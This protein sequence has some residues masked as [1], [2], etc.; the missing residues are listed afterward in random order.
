MTEPARLL[1][2][3]D[4][5]LGGDYA[6]R[7][8][9][10]PR[11]WTE[12]FDGVVP[13]FEE[14][15]LRIGNLESPL[16]ESTAPRPKRNLLG[17]RPDSVAALD[18]LGF[19]V[20]CLG[21]NH[22]TDQGAEGITETRTLL[23]SDGIAA[24]GAGGN[25]CEARRPAFAQAGDLS[26]AF[27]GYAVEGRDVGAEMAT[28]SREGCVPLSMENIESDIAGVCDR[29]D[30]IVVSLHWGYQYDRYPDPGQIEMARAIIDLGA[31]VVYGHH[32]HVLQGVERYKNGVILYSLGNFFFS[33][34]VRTDGRLLRLPRECH[35]TAAIVCQIGRSGVQSVS[36]VPLVVDPDLRMTVLEGRAK[37]LE[38]RFVMDLSGNLDRPDFAVFWEAHHSRTERTRRRREAQ[39]VLHDDTERLRNRLRKSG[40]TGTLTSLKWNDARSLT[41]FLGRSFRMIC[42][43]FTMGRT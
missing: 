1:F 36:V 2:V 23:E 16:H 29:A 11:A 43:W 7:Y 31:T 34:F 9:H 25:L 32:P 21:N 17:A 37:A 33:N 39:T 30:H 13:V 28:E 8:G 40:I 22:I 41:R 27:L 20:L 35:T 19:D 10:G 38:E 26:F 14:A 3:G 18:F 5:S 15:D 42:G 6:G 12:P 24:F 4:I